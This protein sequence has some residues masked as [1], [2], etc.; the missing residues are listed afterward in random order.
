MTQ[1]E[2]LSDLCGLILIGESGKDLASRNDFVLIAE[3]VSISKFPDRWVKQ[4]P[5][6]R[7]ADLDPYVQNKLHPSV[8]PPIME[9][10]K[11]G[12][13]SVIWK[14][15]NASKGGNHLVPGLDYMVD[16]LKFP[17]Q[18]PR[19]SKES[20]KKCVAWRCPTGTQHLFC[21]PIMAVSGQSPAS[22]GQV[23]DSKYLNLVFGH[24]EATHNKLFLS[25]PTKYT[26]ELS[27]PLVLVW[28]SFELIHRALTTIVFI[29]YCQ[30]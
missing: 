21:W 7:T 30:K 1:R 20:L 11:G 13:V 8:S 19:V 29:Q 26:L 6:P 10:N 23:V 28:P 14:F 18:G 16:A 5:Y 24:S 9:S 27:W 12:S 25:S 17:N 15:C 2:V 4:G 3:L 22:N